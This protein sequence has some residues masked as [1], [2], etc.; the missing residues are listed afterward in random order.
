V[1]FFCGFAGQK[2]SG[3]VVME[4]T[5]TSLADPAGPVFAHAKQKFINK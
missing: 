1:L 3:V 2:I 5:L 4:V